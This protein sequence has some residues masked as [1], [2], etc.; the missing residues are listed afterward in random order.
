M[1]TVGLTGGIGTGKTTVAGFFQDLNIPVFFADQLSKQLVNTSPRIRQKIIQLLGK[2]AYQGTMLNSSFVADLVFTDA[3]LLNQLNTIIHPAVLK[4]FE[5]WLAKQSSHYVIKEAALIF[6]IGSQKLYDVIITVTSPIELR[7]ERLMTQRHLSREDILRRIQ[8][9]LS[10]KDKIS[11][12]DFVIPNTDITK[13]KQQVLQIH[14]A[15]EELLK[16]TYKKL[17]T[18]V[19]V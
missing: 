9:Q 4:N 12:S 13:T 19:I 17:I 11:R 2:D 15:I 10:D 7:I 6:E 5:N 8:N 1:I 16:K 3:T 18:N 14:K